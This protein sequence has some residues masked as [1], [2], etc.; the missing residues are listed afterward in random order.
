MTD[1]TY[2]FTVAHFANTEARFRRH[3]KPVKETT[4]MVHLDDML[5]LITQDDV[6][7]RRVL[8]RTKRS[9]MEDFS[10]YMEVEDT[11]G[12]ARTISVSRQLVLFC[13]ERRKAWRMLQSKAG[14][15][16]IDYLAQKDALA[17]FDEDNVPMSDR[18]G[19]MRSRFDA[20]LAGLET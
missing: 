12:N 18:F 14:I 10:V 2:H 6:V 11:D 13:V 4:G 5:L 3:L 9:D 16:N 19:E 8:D 15:E 17:S 7:H 1:R 20:A